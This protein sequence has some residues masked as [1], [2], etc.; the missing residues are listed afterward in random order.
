MLVIMTNTSRHAL[1]KSSLPGHT[2]KMQSFI[3]RKPSYFVNFNLCSPPG[4]QVF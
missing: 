4:N 2:I 3:G 1:I